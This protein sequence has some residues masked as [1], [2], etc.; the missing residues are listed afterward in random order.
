MQK[1]NFF[2]FCKILEKNK[3]KKLKKLQK[4]QKL[5]KFLKKFFCLLFWKKKK[6]YLFI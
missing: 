3:N 4:F 1:S 5:Q 2:F 6:D